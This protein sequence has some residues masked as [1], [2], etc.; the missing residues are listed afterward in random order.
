MT[1]YQVTGATKYF[2]GYELYI[3]S[4]LVYGYNP[5][6]TGKG[7]MSLLNPFL[8]NSVVASGVI[9]DSV[10]ASDGAGSTSYFA[11]EPT[12]TSTT[13]GKSTFAFD[14]VQSGSW[15]DPL[16]ASTF[17]YTMLSDS[18]FAEI[19]GF[20]SGFDAFEVF[21][22]GVDEGS[23]VAGDTFEFPAD[24]TSFTISGISP[25]GV[26]FPLQLAFNTP[27]ASFDVTFASVPESSTWTMWLAG[28]AGLGLATFYRARMSGNSPPTVERATYRQSYWL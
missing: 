22:G 2:P 4:Q 25:L 23:F 12:S 8:T 28:F 24:T 26:P 19:L 6:S 9:S 18:D 21:V 10:A 14:D 17:K 5:A 16:S 27:T 7:P 3:G 11:V 15:F 13:S 1:S 20:P